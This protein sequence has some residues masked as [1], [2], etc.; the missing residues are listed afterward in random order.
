MAE[1]D[2]VYSDGSAPRAS[3]EDFSTSS[4]TPSLSTRSHWRYRIQAPISGC[5]F[6]KSPFLYFT[7]SFLCDLLRDS[8]LATLCCL[9]GLDCTTARITKPLKRFAN[10]RSRAA[11]DPP[12]RQGQRTSGWIGQPVD[13]CAATPSLPSVP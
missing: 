10:L 1:S 12:A 5:A 6:K 11:E 13:S 2:A 8:T 3:N 9:S 7:V 4:V